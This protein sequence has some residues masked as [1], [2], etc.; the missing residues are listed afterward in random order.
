[1]PR[2][3]AADRATETV[4][5]AAEVPG[6]NATMPNAQTNQAAAERVEAA[7]SAYVSATTWQAEYG[8]DGCTAQAWNEARTVEEAAWM[9]RHGFPARSMLAQLKNVDD[10]QLRARFDAGDLIAAGVLV[11]RYFERGESEQAR[12]LVDLAAARGSIYVLYRFAANHY[13]SEDVAD[14]VMALTALRVAFMRGD[15]AAATELKI[16]GRSMFSMLQSANRALVEE[17]S[18]AYL[19]ELDA[20]RR[21]RGYPPLTIEPRPMEPKTME[22]LAHNRPSL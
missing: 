19:A 1:M 9:H 8:C 5:G 11:D 13:T 10:A 2:H 22:D 18:F 12:A 21:A 6:A 17:Q 16:I 15:H 20:L 3:E 7:A 4:V 14:Q